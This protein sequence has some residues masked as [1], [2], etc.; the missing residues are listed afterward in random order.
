MDFNYQLYHQY[1]ERLTLPYS[2]KR[3]LEWGSHEYNSLSME[4]RVPHLAYAL[5]HG[6]DLVKEI[7]EHLKYTDSNE[8]YYKHGIAETIMYLRTGEK[9]RSFL[10]GD[11][12]D[13]VELADL[14]ALLKDELMMR[15]IVNDVT[16]K[17]ELKQM[18]I[19]GT[20]LNELPLEQECDYLMKPCFY[21]EH[22]SLDELMYHNPWKTVFFKDYSNNSSWNI[23]LADGEQAVYEGDR[24]ILSEYNERHKKSEDKQFILN[25]PPEPY[26][27]NLRDPKLVIL[28]LNPGYEERLNG[29]LV[30][31]LGE[32]YRKE[33]IKALYDNINFE[34][35]SRVVFNDVDDI[36][37]NGYWTEKLS[38]LGKD[39]KD[40]DGSF[41]SR[42]ALIQFIPYFS[43]RFDSQCSMEMLPS[44]Y[45]TRHLIRRILF[46][47]PK[48]MFLIMRSRKRWESL[49][50]PEMSQF[51]DRFVE[52]INPQNQSVSRNNIKDKK[53]YDRILKNLRK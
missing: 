31:M 26:R 41:M 12:E 6:Y 45:Y 36:I 51:P 39:I 35:G 30:T 15:Y 2:I 24:R 3:M 52:A 50:G 11:D 13:K 18:H 43:R 34:M 47:H 44:Q 20:I 38:Q 46:E 27:G 49:I 32:Q 53:S 14:V 1:G 28:S 40:T 23:K 16:H 4:K 17:H 29:K 37:G 48:T 10:H 7:R 33:F 5:F 19:D 8:N 22:F 42:I 9:Q 25:I 21:Q